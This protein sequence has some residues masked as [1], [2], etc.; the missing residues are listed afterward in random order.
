MMKKDSKAAQYLEAYWPLGCSLVGSIIIALITRSCIGT[1]IFSNDFGSTFDKILDST[2][3]FS[4]IIVGFTGVLMGILFSISE[5]KLMR[6]FF[7]TRARKLLKAYFARNIISGMLLV[8]SSMLLYMRD[9]MTFETKLII[10]YVWS[11]LLIYVFCSA[12]RIIAIIMH[13]LFASVDEDENQEPS[14]RKMDDSRVRELEQQYNK[15]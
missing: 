15:K 7:S 1:Q 9:Y 8:V 13:I 3:V 4:S 12:Y 11:V 5:K 6:R 2:I 10:S 14:G